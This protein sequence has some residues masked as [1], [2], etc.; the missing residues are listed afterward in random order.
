MALHLDPDFADDMGLVAVGGDLKPETLIEAY[1][2]GVFPWFDDGDPVLWWSPDPRAIF[3][4]G[5]LHIARR[6]ART[7]RTGKFRYTIDHAFG[8][9]IR[10]CGD[11]EEGSWIHPQMISAYEQ[12]HRLGI[13]HSVEAWQGN[14]LAGGIYGVAIRGLFAAESMFT[15]RTDG[16]KAALVHLTNHLRSRGFQLLD[17]QML[18]PHTARLGAIEIPREEYLSR[19]QKA[20]RCE[21]RFEDQKQTNNQV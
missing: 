10:A 9:V 16:S 1:C 13:A 3:E 12:L 11:R 7:I 19:L 14:E 17:I 15:R 2:W 20:L 21:V 4:L 8:E 18:T 6:L 5:G